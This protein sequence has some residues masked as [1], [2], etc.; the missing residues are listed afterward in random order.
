MKHA[1][2]S[3]ASLLAF[4]LL[5]SGIVYTS[6][7]PQLYSAELT[8]VTAPP[9]QRT[10]TLKT[11]LYYP[12]AASQSSLTAQRHSVGARKNAS[13]AAVPADATL[14]PLSVTELFHELLAGGHAVIS[15]PLKQGDTYFTK[16]QLLTALH[17]IGIG[18]RTE[19][20][21]GTGITITYAPTKTIRSE[22]KKTK[23]SRGTQTPPLP[24]S[25][26]T[27]PATARQ[28][29]KLPS[30]LHYT[31]HL[32]ASAATTPNANHPRK[33]AEA[34]TKLRHPPSIQVHRQRSKGANLQ[35]ITVSFNAQLLAMTASTITFK[36]PFMAAPLTT[37]AVLGENIFIDKH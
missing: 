9:A 25:Q 7:F 16:T 23:F 2:N 8:N 35:A 31:F 12:S 3:S 13:A 15:L 21:T 22:L 33:L 36:A 24:Q 4:I 10:L 34:I 27:S 5:L 6:M 30:K 32:P 1:I 29:A 20:V 37:A 14:L 17:N 18:L 19:Q 26:Y 11:K 28:S